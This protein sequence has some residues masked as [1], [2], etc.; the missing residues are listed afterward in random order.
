MDATTRAAPAGTDLA[1]PAGRYSAPA[2]FFHWA[3][4]LLMLIVLPVGLIID[5][6]YE[7]E[8]AKNLL[9]FIHENLGVTIWLLV[10]ARLAW[11]FMSPPPPLPADT[12][13]MIRLAAHGTH[14]ALYVILLA[15]PIGG[16]IGTNAAGFPLDFF[17][18]IPLPNPTGENE[19]LSQLVLR[20][21]W[22][23]GLALAVI[24][25]AHVGGA[26]YHLVIRKDGVF[27]R[28]V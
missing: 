8:W 6:F 19:A 5:R 21:H 3:I 24:L 10:L 7:V 9:Y 2:R 14:I 11:R 17:G 25:V 28:M 22:I 12:P 20:W 15:Q 18:L 27:Q 26:L 1:H 4:A 16:F 13:A 23:T